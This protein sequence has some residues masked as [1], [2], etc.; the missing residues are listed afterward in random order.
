MFRRQ[1][2]DER[3]VPSE[4]A[5]RNPSDLARWRQ[6]LADERAEADVYRDLAGRRTGEERDI[7]L[8]LAAAEGRHE[9]HWLTLLGEEVGKPRRP[10]LRVGVCS[11]PRTAG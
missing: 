3:A 9:Q 5:R 10:D 11:C 8:A 1:A 2:A 7:L 6:H 4:D